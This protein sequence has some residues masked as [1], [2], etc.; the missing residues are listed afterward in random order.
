MVHRREEESVC[1]RD[2]E[3]RSERYEYYETP[4][5]HRYSGAL[6]TG[7]NKSLRKSMGN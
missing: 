6:R 4:T 5:K 1:V 2:R 7:L 3:R